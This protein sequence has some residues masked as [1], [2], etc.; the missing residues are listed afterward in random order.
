MNGVKIQKN[1]IVPEC[2]MYFVTFDQNKF[3]RLMVTFSIVR[4]QFSHWRVVLKFIY[5][6]RFSFYHIRHYGFHKENRWQSFN[7]FSLGMTFSVY[8]SEES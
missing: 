5:I 6:F 1:E 2:Q 8:L 3:H 7:M 4:K